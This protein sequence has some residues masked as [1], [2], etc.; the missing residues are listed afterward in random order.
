MTARFID[1]EAPGGKRTP[2]RE[3]LP[4]ETPFVIQIFPIYTC[5]FRCK[6][7]H[8]S[9]P[10]RERPFVTDAVSMDL[11]LFKKCVDDMCAFSDKLKTLRF[12][13]MGEPLLHGDIAEM[14]AYSKKKRVANCVE[15]LTN[16]SLL[17]R[18]TADKLID[19][20]LDRLVVSLQGLDEKKYREISGIDIAFK[21]FLDNLEYFYKRKKSTHVYFKVVD[22]ALEGESGRSR[23]F[24][25]FGNICDSIGIEHAVPIFPGAR[26]NA[27]LE[28]AAG[29]G[30]VSQF[31][32]AVSH[33]ETCPQPFYLMQINPD[34]KVVGCHSIP[35]P[36]IL[37]DCN[38]E[39]L[40]GIWNGRNF[41]SFRLRLLDGRSSVCAVCKECNIMNLRMFPEDDIGA[42]AERL[43]RYY[44]L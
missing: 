37:G 11:N 7:C 40:A 12:V 28:R 34:G 20:G 22:C 33:V 8:F 2:L 4:L 10:K 30:R 15:I 41:N 27:A 43:K 14:V 9:V 44:G 13:G 3:A 35:Y 6:Y 32:L 17:T 36:E 38:N 23:F 5:N 25:L 1:K 26:Y 39:M 19:A 16:G 31:G 18:D 29:G 24:E 42:D 21:Q